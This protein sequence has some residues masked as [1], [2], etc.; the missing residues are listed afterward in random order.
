M[1]D[2]KI[3]D[4]R[5]D[6]VTRPTPAMRKAMAEA[7][8]GDDVFG[9]DPTVRELEETTAELLGKEAAL[10]VPS[11]TMGNE[12][13]VRIHASSGD[14]IIVEA[15][16]HIF[17]AEAGA[18]AALSGVTCRLLQGRQG[19]FTGSD[20]LGVL[21]QPDVHYAPQKL[22]CVEN[23][24]NV[25]AGKIWP[26][27]TLAEL[28]TAAHQRGLAVHMDGARLWNAAI[29]TGVSEKQY[30]SHCDTVS[31]CFSK[32]LGAPVGSALAGSAELVARARRFRK[33]W[34]GGMRQAGII[35]AGALYALRHHR[36]RMAEDH[37]NARKLAE[38]L[39]QIPGVELIGA[40]FETNIVR[41]FTN[42]RSASDIVAALKSQGVF[43]LSTG[44]DSMRAVTHLEIS[45]AEINKAIAEFQQALR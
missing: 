13:A 12:L 42:V 8:V 34:G 43:I 23:T 30:A 33:M 7:Q 44:P 29:A 24:H 19:I 15:S 27:A 3:I 25:G 21:R 6:T 14:E 39:S 40:P 2:N 22:V 32:G 26:L 5:S 38:G 35:A 20:L 9:D 45:D 11:G 41:F 37:A 16:S 28:A 18:P 31:V 1:P 10:F 36:A 4:L 17:S